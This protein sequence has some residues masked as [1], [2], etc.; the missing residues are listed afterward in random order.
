MLF[1]FFLFVLVTYSAS[2]IVVEQKIFQEVR[3]YISKCATDNPSW[4]R[5]K[6]CLLIS[7]VTCTGFWFGAFFTFL[8]LNVFN[9]SMIDPF[10]G[11]LLGSVCN[12]HLKLLTEAY[13]G[14]VE[15]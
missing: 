4:F 7:C 8:G 1:K 13:L 11:G 12:Y 5:K 3:D 14:D 6:L 2:L 15:V 9:I 10:F